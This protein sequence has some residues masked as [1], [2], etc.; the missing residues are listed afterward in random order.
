MRISSVSMLALVAALAL[1]APAAASDPLR[2]Q[3]FGLDMIEADAAREV[4]GGAG[5]VVA[6]IDTGVLARHEDLEGRLLAGRDLVDDDGTPQDGNGHGTHVTGI[7]AAAAGNGRGIEGVAPAARVLPVRVLGDDGS[8]TSED[9]AQGIDYA[10]AQGA[11]VI[12]LSLGDLPVVGTALGGGDAYIAAIERAAA[13]GV[14]VVAAAGNDSLP[15]CEQPAVQ[16][17]ILCV[18]AVDRRE[19]RSFYSSTGNITAPGGSG[20]GEGED[21]L[22][23]F[24]D[25]GYAELAGTSQATPHVAGVAALLASRGVHGS[26]A[27]ERIL[28]TARDAGPAGPDMLYGAGIVNARAAVEGLQGAPGGASRGPLSVRRR[29]RIRR[30]LRRG[31]RMRCRPAAAGRC[32]ARIRARGRLVARGSRA[33]AAGQTAVV[34]ARPTRAGRRLLRRT[35]GRRRATLR[36]RV[37]GAGRVKRRLTFVR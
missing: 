20:L 5:A 6:V 8:G 24:S 27:V 3:Q 2:G 12:N 19:M 18:G 33:V 13:A 14:V 1:A 29:Q 11:H 30:V 15:I 22:S 25:G 4:T 37:P 17:E 28:T 32:A 23:T 10:V 35:S 26:A 34:V 9:V 21:I 7:V 31:V 16:G 36:A